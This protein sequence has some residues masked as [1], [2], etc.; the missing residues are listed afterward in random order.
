MSEWAR[1]P[2]VEIH[3][4]SWQGDHEVDPDTFGSLLLNTTLIVDGTT[5]QPPYASLRLY[6]FLVLTVGLKFNP[7]DRIAYDEAWCQEREAE[8]S[9]WASQYGPDQWLE[10]SSDQEILLPVGSLTARRSALTY[11]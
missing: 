4:K 8:L 1:M 6:D 3:V 2:D 11:E 10:G 5:L 9:A 7:N